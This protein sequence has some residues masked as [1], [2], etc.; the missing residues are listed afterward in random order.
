MPSLVEP[1]ARIDL[2]WIPL[3]AGG[4]GFVRLNGRIYEWFK[5]RAESR[6]PM[7]VL[8]TA[9][10]VYVPEGRFVVETM[11]PS[12]DRQPQSRGVVLQAAVGAVPMARW[13]TFR[14]E[15][16]RWR[17]G[18]LPDSA[19]AIGGP[20]L[21]GTDLAQARRL[22]DL[23]ASVPPLVWGRDQQGVGEM[24][25]S[26]SVISWLLARSGLPM[27][28]IDPP[29]GRRAP[30]WQAGLAIAEMGTPSATSS[31]RIPNSIG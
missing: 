20:Q 23:T 27:G 14:Y 2:Y 11:W 28:E 10:E 13:R 18:V 30:G 5:A 15:V 19:A 12:P 16:R 3:G 9:L 22:L 17:D 8:H 4:S 29:P 25:N 21:V 7:G 24:W 6:P 26:N 31:R 1:V